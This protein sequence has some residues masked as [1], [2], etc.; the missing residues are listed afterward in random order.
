MIS[1]KPPNTLQR[2]QGETCGAIFLLGYN[3]FPK[4]F[5]MFAYYEGKNCRRVIVIEEA[6]TTLRYPSKTGRCEEF[7]LATTGFRVSNQSSLLAELMLG[8]HETEIV[9]IT[10]LH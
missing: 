5:V 6:R 8:P 1:N 4:E 3:I 7:Q 2:W 10:L 9:K